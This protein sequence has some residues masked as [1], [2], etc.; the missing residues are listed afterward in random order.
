MLGLSLNSMYK[1]EVV[2]EAKAETIAA[3]IVSNNGYIYNESGERYH[4]G[5]SEITEKYGSYTDIDSVAKLNNFLSTATVGQV[6][7]LTKN[8]I[9]TIGNESAV[10]F[11]GVLDGNGFGLEITGTQFTMANSFTAGTTLFGEGAEYRYAGMIVGANSGTIKNIRVTWLSGLNANAEK[12]GDGV[13]TTPNINQ[14]FVTGLV[15]GL[16]RGTI[17]NIEVNIEGGFAIGKGANDNETDVRGNSAIAGGVCGALYNG[18]ISNCTVNNNGGVLSLADGSKSGT[19]CKSGASAAGG[20]VGTIYHSATSTLKSCILTGNGNVRAVFYNSE[21]NRNNDGFWGFAGGAV[22]CSL[23]VILNGSGTNNVKGVQV[24]TLVDGQID[25]L[26]SSWTGTTYHY[27]KHKDNDRDNFEQLD[28]AQWGNQSGATPWLGTHK[29]ALF[30]I[31]DPTTNATDSYGSLLNIVIAYEYNALDGS[32][33]I[34]NNDHVKTGA[35]NEVYST[36]A[37]GMVSVGY[38]SNSKP[39]IMAVANGYDAT[40]INNY[41]TDFQYAT[42]AE[43]G[44]IIWTVDYLGY[45]DIKNDNDEVIGQEKVYY[46][47]L[48]PTEEAPAEVRYFMSGEAH[49]YVYSFGE[50]VN[51]F[52]KTTIQQ[53]MLQ[54]L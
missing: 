52:L 19:G 27:W 11:K 26:I 49:V 13:I 39:R 12:T 41:T 54:M 35:W 46:T 28:Y 17:D 42:P 37:G 21:Q 22:G 15:C 47:Q 16:N 53:A 2:S 6:G 7:V 8:L 33:Y 34:D 44:R 40:N 30:G 43:G 4:M 3:T 20:I 51:V 50:I 14:T 45:K 23:A 48:S 1:D 25:G 9:Y 36:N 31:V 29:G 10:D 38:D 32:T 24:Y 18:T 5:D